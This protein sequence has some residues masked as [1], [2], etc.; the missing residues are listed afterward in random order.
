MCIACGFNPSWEWKKFISELRIKSSEMDPMRVGHIFRF[1]SEFW[2]KSCGMDPL[3]WYLVEICEILLLHVL[4]NDACKF[5]IDPFPISWGPFENVNFLF[6]LLQMQI[7]TGCNVL[8]IAGNPIKGMNVNLSFLS[9]RSKVV[10]W[11]L[12]GGIQDI[13]IRPHYHFS[14]RLHR[15]KMCI[16]CRL[17]PLRIGKF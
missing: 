2:I 9:S 6:F 5:A 8:N 15:C 1:I 17:S 13:Q 12:W 14:S 11:T 4:S 3:I 10:E 16:A 7:W